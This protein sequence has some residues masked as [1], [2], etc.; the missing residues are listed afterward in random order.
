VS[1]NFGAV[2]LD[3]ATFRAGFPESLFERL[4]AFGIGAE[5]QVITDVGSG[6]GTLA[7]GFARRGA[8]VI[9][10][11][12]D[13]RLVEQARQLD[14]QAQVRVDYA[15]GTAEALPLGDRT[16]DV[17]TAGQAWHWFKGRLAASEMARVSRVG[18]RVVIAHFDWLPL[19]GNAVEATERLIKKHNPAWRMGGGNGFHPESIPDLAAAGFNE[20][21]TFSYDV[22]VPYTSE[23]WR[24]RIRAS[25]GVGA[26]LSPAAV[27]AFDIELARLLKESYPSATLLV[28]HRVFAVLARLATGA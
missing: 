19:P 2:A 25:G 11:E 15:L 26:A 12:P 22:A 23:A 17:V 18:G 14:A 28:P 10:V 1:T 7:R 8:R 27:A 20:F 5:G 21:E 16:M 9:G 3:Y 24:G 6:T 4:A 13:E